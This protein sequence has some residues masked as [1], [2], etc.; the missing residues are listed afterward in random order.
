MNNS[1]FCT[2]LD[3]PDVKIIRPVQHGDDRG[4]FSEV[5]N[6]QTLNSAGVELKLVQENFAFSRNVNTLRGIHFQIPPYAQTKLVHVI[7]GSIFDVAVDLRKGSPWYGKWVSAELSFDNWNQILIPAGF[8]HGLITLE[9][10]TAV[11]YKVDEHF[12][13]EHDAGIHWN[14]PEVNIEWPLTST[15]PIL[16]EKDLL[17]P[18]LK[19]FNTPF[20]YEADA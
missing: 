9:P 5:Y 15:S 1:T 20:T 13:K 17:L 2:S 12:S 16:S 3:I 11:M 18:F 4:F 14:D 7:R 6:C 10:D 19:D 8:G